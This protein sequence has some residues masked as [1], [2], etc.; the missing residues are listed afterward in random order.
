[1]S[2]YIGAR[3]WLSKIEHYR[4]SVT[5]SKSLSL[6]RAVAVEEETESIS[7]IKAGRIIYAEVETAGHMI[8]NTNPGIFAELVQNFI[9]DG[10]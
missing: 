6:S 9:E 2:N 5:E 1:M 3:K 7:Y 10:L 8:G 4:T